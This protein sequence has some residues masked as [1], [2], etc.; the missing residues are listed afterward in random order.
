M[1]HL[2]KRIA[3]IACAMALV[4]VLGVALAACG[5]SSNPSVMDVT[6]KLIKEGYTVQGVMPMPGQG[7]DNAYA[8]WAIMATKTVEAYKGEERDEANDKHYAVA[9]VNY[10]DAD[11]VEIMEANI[12]VGRENAIKS[13]EKALKALEDAKADKDEIAEAQAA[14]E[15]VKA[16]KIERKGTLAYIY[17]DQEIVMQL[18]GSFGGNN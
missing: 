15:T 10:D 2:S 1:K 16:V 13:A 14:V 11:Y 18:A 7:E 4:V 6:K 3:T 8:G 12:Y 17:G 5:N 9:V